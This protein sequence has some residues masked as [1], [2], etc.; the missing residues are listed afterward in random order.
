MTRSRICESC[1]MVMQSSSDHG[2]SD[3]LN[4]RCVHCCHPDGAFKT[5]DEVLQGTIE[6]LLSDACEA[7]GFPK[8]A[9]P[10]EARRRAEEILCEKVAWRH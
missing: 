7:A 5:R 8:A 10:D 1:A 4:P 3:P 6:W 9:T 2:V